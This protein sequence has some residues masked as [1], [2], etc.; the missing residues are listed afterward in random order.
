LTRRTCLRKKHF[1]SQLNNTD[2]SDADYQ[3]AKSVW[4]HFDCSTLQD[5]HDIYLKTDVFLADVFQNFRAMAMSVYHL[6]P[7]HHYPLPG[8]SW[9]AFL[10]QTCV[11]LDLITDP[12]I[13][14]MLEN[15]I[16]GGIS[17]ITHR[18]AKANNPLLPDY[19]SS[20]PKSY[21]MYLD[22]NNLYGKAMT[23]C[24]PTGNFRFLSE[25]EV[26]NFDLDSVDD[27][28]RK[29]CVL[30]V[31]LEYPPELHD[32]HNDY[33]LA[34]ERLTVSKEMLSPYCNSFD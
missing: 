9:D 12:E 21:L 2:I 34:A 33:P 3:H 30:E 25:A 24:L 7:A 29:G 13:Y 15:S 10:L 16:R 27:F 32:K 11:T 23:E 14:L 28:S 1:Y 22:C 4:N 31:D 26:D 5:Y 20:L 6:D 8:F 19:D 17:T 18:H